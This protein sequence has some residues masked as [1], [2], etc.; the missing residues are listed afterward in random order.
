[1]QTA[2]YNRR[3][4]LRREFILKLLS[5]LISCAVVMSA[6]ASA[7]WWIEADDLALRNDIQLL[8]DSG[9]IRQPINTYPL[10]WSGIVQDLQSVDADALTPDLR[11]ALHRVMMLW[12]RDRRD[13]QAS[14]SLAGETE[15]PA[16]V[17]FG[18]TLRDKA[19]AQASGSYQNDRV[20]ARL[21]VSQ[22]SQPFDQNRTRLD[23][24]YVAVKAGN[25]I[26][27]AGALEK[28]WGP[29]FDTSA[30]LSTNA[31][32]VPAVTLSRNSSAAA[33]EDW[34]PAWTFTT[35][36][37][38]LSSRAQ[39]P[40][41][42]LWQ[43]RLGI[44]P[45][46]SLEMGFSWV[47]T[48]GGQGYGNGLNDWFD[49]LFRGGTLEGSENM[50]AG[51]DLRWTTSL[52]DQPFGVYWSAIA[53]DVSTKTLQL[54]KVSYQ[55]GLDTYVR[56]LSSR[57]Y[58]E[59]IDTA[60]DCS[61]DRKF[62][63]YYEHSTHHDGY[64]RYG[65]AFGTSYDNDSKA[66]NLG[67]LTQLDSSTSWHNKLA[68]LR[69]NVDGARVD[70]PSQWTQTQLPARTVLLWRTEQQWRDHADQWK[71]GLE[72][73]NTLDKASQERDWQTELFLSWSRQF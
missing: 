57:I 29:S 62:N 14:L 50:L 21:Q 65:R 39:V 53:D 2:V 64:R 17:R 26:V 61:N 32:P 11:D 60:I 71:W 56:P 44:K 66:L 40:D 4:F 67:M 18:D 31:R 20:S 25:W 52:L 15:Q 59:I 54:Y 38:Q 55:L 58:L 47:M 28:Y 3:N 16:I 33:A 48:Y 19:Q 37:G 1:M 69:L 36:F 6:P 73:S 10:M 22:V 45:L 42:K 46:N 7:G 63:C 70:L 12:Q 43:A 68:W 72:F 9:Y 23:G 5:V 34:L 13:V 51:Y 8:A 49:G 41:A 24:S 30:I 27:S 35:S